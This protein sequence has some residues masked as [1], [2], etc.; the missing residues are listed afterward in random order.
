MDAVG[1]SGKDNPFTKKK[2]RQAV[3]YA[4]NRQAMVKHLVKGVSKVVN[5]ACYPPQHGCVQKGVT[6]YA[7]NPEK[8]KKLLAQAGYPDGFTTDFY[9][10][11]ERPYAEAMVNYLDAVGIHAKLRFLQ[12]PSFN[13]KYRNGKAPI[14]FY[15][16]GSEGVNDV[17]GIT[18][19]FFEG[20]PNDYAHDKKVS[21]WLKK[22][23]TTLNKDKREAVYSKALQRISK[24]AYWAPLFSYSI[25]YAFDKDL[26]FKPSQDG[27]PRFTSATWK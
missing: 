26:D 8:A 7:Y 12:Y 5:T 10:Y 27:I 18:S 22:G 17:S 14:A 20:G 4:I 2:V 9:A 25:N 6:D 23:D 19:Y 21:K 15:T 11:R 24:Q 3:A 1:R 16:W 13:E